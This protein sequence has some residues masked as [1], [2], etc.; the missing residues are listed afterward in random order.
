MVNFPDWTKFLY[1]SFIIL[2]IMRLYQSCFNFFCSKG[3][4]CL[5]LLKS[6]LVSGRLLFMSSIVSAP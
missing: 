2:V 1:N 4:A 3:F 6:K 5:G